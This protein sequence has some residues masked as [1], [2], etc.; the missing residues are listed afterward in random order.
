[1]MMRTVAFAGFCGGYHWVAFMGTCLSPLLTG[2]GAVSFRLALTSRRFLLHIGAGSSC[3]E[4]AAC[5]SQ[6]PILRQGGT[7]RQNMPPLP[8]PNGDDGPSVFLRLLN[9]PVGKRPCGTCTTTIVDLPAT[10]SADSGI[11]LL[12]ASA[13]LMTTLRA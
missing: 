11:N 10:L 13:T 8:N 6:V 3:R 4:T 2:A 9:V 7:P 5:C 1:M 12:F